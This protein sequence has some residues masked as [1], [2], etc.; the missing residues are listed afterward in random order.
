MNNC[1]NCKESEEKVIELRWMIENYKIDNPRDELQKEQKR[2][3]N[4]LI[5]FIDNQIL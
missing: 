4:K 1:W 2:K 3:M 5:E